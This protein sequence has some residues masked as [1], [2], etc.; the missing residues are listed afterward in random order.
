MI[1][2]GFEIDGI[3]AD[4]N[5]LD[6]AQP[7]RG[8]DD[9]DG[10]RLEVM[11]QHVRITHLEREPV[12]V[13]NRTDGDLESG[14]FEPPE[15]QSELGSDIVVKNDLQHGVR[16]HPASLKPTRH[17]IGHPIPRVVWFLQIMIALDEFQ[18]LVFGCQM[19]VDDMCIDRK[20][21]RI[22]HALQDQ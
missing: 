4:S 20:D 13:S 8:L 2:H 1:S 17:Q 7:R 12:A 22:G 16:S 19:I 14:F 9:V 11:P 18:G 5:L 6:Q 3:D 15:T 21:P 10:D